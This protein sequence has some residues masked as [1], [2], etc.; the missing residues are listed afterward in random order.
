[1]VFLQEYTM[2]DELGK[3][4][5]ATVCKVCPMVQACVLDGIVGQKQRCLVINQ[6]H[7]I[8]ML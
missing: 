6:S 5:F 3:G 4:G 7:K 8:T 1:M 2:L